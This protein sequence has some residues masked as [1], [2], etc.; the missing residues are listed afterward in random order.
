[1][2]WYGY[3]QPKAVSFDSGQTIR[4]LT[5]ILD[6]RTYGYV[7]T[8]G[9]LWAAAFFIAIEH[10]SAPKHGAK[11]WNR[12]TDRWLSVANKTLKL[13]ESSQEAEQPPPLSFDAFAFLF[14]D[15]TFANFN[16]TIE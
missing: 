4:K 1:M 7:A 12:I 13:M 11:D 8:N 5:Q 2:P 3:Q 9:R 14:H 16:T 6:T 10:T 15:P